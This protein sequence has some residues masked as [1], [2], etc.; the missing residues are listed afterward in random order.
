MTAVNLMPRHA[1]PS[2]LQR[3]RAESE[4]GANYAKSKPI[5]SLKGIS[6][7][8]YKWWERRQRVVLLDGNLGSEYANWRR[9]FKL[10]RS[11]YGT[12]GV[13][14]KFHLKV[15]GGNSRGSDPRLEKSVV[16]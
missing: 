1:T 9:G 16:N 5:L 10:M 12:I 15:R 7:R 6:M 11:N 13:E 2:Q 4:L 3:G 14:G 8:K